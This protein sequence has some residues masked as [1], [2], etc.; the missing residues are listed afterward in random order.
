MVK[1]ILDYLK[2]Y[3]GRTEFLEDLEYM[4]T[5]GDQTW[6]EMRDE[7]REQ[8]RQQENKEKDE[9]DEK[10]IGS[11]DKIRR[12]EVFHNVPQENSN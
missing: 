7:D 4:Y 6:R 2:D 5:E 10:A 11:K 1:E 12:V 9:K 8:A 3:P